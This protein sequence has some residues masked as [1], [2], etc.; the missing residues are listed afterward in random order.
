MI[1]DILISLFWFLLTLI[2]FSMTCIEIFSPDLADSI[3]ERYKVL[4][5]RTMYKNKIYKLP[6]IWFVYYELM[7]SIFPGVKHDGKTDVKLILVW[8]FLSILTLLALKIPISYLLYVL[9]F[10]G[11]IISLIGFSLIERAISWFLNLYAHGK[12]LG[13]LGLLISIPSVIRELLD[14]LSQFR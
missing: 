2:G 10:F 5:E 8:M 6:L 1:Q 7:D 11:I 13:A 12:E 14:L 4:R 9:L 3:E